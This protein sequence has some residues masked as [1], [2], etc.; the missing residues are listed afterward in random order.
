MR[1]SLKWI[2]AATVYVAI[3]AAAFGTGD[4]YFADALWA[5][6]LLAVVYA[7]L[8]TA[9]AS[10]RRRVAAAGFV[11]A[12]VCFALCVAF[13]G[14]TVPTTRLLIATGVGSIV[15]PTVIA[16]PNSPRPS[17]NLNLRYSEPMSAGQS[18]SFSSTLGAPTVVSPSANAPSINADALK[19]TGTFTL[20]SMV[21]AY[22]APMA[23]VDFASYVRA[24]FAV[25]TLASASWF[26]GGLDGVS[27]GG[28]SA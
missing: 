16:A 24:A 8:I 14:D 12:S 4:W 15:Q 6:T 28:Q 13:G 21:V 25:A 2:L 7:V 23:A 20:R 1:F 9:F 26:P 10:G 18:P 11:V 17:P 19:T 5:L 27:G 3:A 22:P